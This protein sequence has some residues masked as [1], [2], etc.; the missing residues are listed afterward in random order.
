M[1]QKELLKKALILLDEAAGSLDEALLESPTG[2]L[3]TF[4]YPETRQNV[5]AIR[6]LRREL[7]D[8]WNCV[9]RDQ[10]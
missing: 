5:R 2:L 10:S 7:D 8:N 1:T 4:P 6:R 9:W 3:R